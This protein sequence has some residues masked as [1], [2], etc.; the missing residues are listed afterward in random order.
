MGA[1][2][3][4][5]HADRFCAFFGAL[6]WLLLIPFAVVG[7]IVSA[8][9][10]GVAPEDAGRGKGVAGLISC[11]IAAIFGFLRLVAGWGIV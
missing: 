4:V 11:G 7:T 5:R 2:F 3:F 6:N 10:L 9:A 1:I 8:V